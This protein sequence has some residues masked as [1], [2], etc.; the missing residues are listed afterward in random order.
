MKGEKSCCW[1]PTVLRLVLGPLFVFPG[2]MKLLNPSMIIGMLG[3]LGFPMP[4]FWAWLLL[5]SEI[6]FGISVFLGFRVKYTVWPLVVVLVVATLIVYLPG[7][8]KDPMVTGTVLFHLLGIASLVS[9][10]LSG[11]GAWAADKE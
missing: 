11:A 3:T 5:L 4:T 6:I 9:V 10:F 2:V 8:G 7:L 1:G